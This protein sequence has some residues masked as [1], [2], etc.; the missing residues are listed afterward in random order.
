M[1]FLIPEPYLEP[2]VTKVDTHDH[3]DDNGQ[4]FGGLIASTEGSSK[5]QETYSAEHTY[6]RAR[7][8]DMLQRLAQPQAKEGDPGLVQKTNLPVR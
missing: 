8:Q 7:Y 2:N 6:E 4:F 1:N 5:E 3:F